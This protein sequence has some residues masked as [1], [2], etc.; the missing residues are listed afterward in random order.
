MNR[1]EPAFHSV[2]K[3]SN[4]DPLQSFAKVPGQIP[5]QGFTKLLM[6]TIL[7]DDIHQVIDECIGFVCINSL[8]QTVV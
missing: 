1:A 4:A 2:V 6:M 5:D 7:L 8:N 3:K